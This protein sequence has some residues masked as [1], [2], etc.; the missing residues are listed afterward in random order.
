MLDFMGGNF[1]WWIG[2]VEDRLDPDQAGRV[3]VRVMG[4]HTQDQ[5]ELSTADLPWAQVLMGVNT[6]GTSG[7]GENVHSLV[8]GTYVFGFWID[9]T[10]AQYPVVFGVF[11]GIENS[12]FT[13]NIEINSPQYPTDGY[14][15]KSSVNMLAK[16]DHSSH[17]T[18]EQKIKTRA[19][20]IPIARPYETNTVLSKNPNKAYNR[21]RW[22]EPTPMG[23]TPIYPFNKVMESES[24]HIQ[25]FD[26]TPGNERIHTMHSSGT[27][28][29]I[30]ADGKRIT[31]VV[32]DDFEIVVNDKNV[33]VNGHCNITVNGDANLLVQGNMNQEIGG[34][35]HLTVGGNFVKKISGN[36]VR[37]VGADSSDNISGNMLSRCGKDE[38]KTV[39]KDS[40]TLVGQDHGVIVGGETKLQTKGK[41]TLKSRDSLNVSAPNSIFDRL[42]NVK[43]GATFDDTA[44][45]KGEA[46]LQKSLSVAVDVDVSGAVSSIGDVVSGVSGSQ[47]SLYNH[48]HSPLGPAPIKE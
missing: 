42:V 16:E 27:F 31:K 8:E 33:F 46:T 17:D 23:G 5:T 28:Q 24:G 39:A 38:N 12:L 20:K 18:L 26:D 48:K 34:D 40:T 10:E 1:V 36:D 25:E 21:R 22:D 29:E 11:N 6:G 44:T 3:R 2:Q 45:I 4:H 43:G 37:E 30:Q 47:V 41:Y 35:Y 19:T 13:K 7:I 15:N 14:K 32:G 9:G